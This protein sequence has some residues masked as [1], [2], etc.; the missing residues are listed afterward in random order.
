M[1]QTVAY[2]AYGVAAA[3]ITA[4]WQ[5]MRTFEENEG[6]GIIEVTQGTLTANAA[7]VAAV[8]TRDKFVIGGVTYAVID[9]G[10][11][12]ATVELFLEART[13]RTRGRGH[14]RAR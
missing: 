13:Q 1:G 8:S 7:T 11:E 2:T 9:I 3:N 4:Q 6:D 5:P 14:I 12:G 10:R